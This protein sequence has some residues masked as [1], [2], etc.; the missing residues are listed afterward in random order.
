MR[1][2]FRAR[3]KDGVQSAPE[4]ETAVIRRRGDQGAVAV[5]CRADSDRGAD[6]RFPDLA[7]APDRDGL[8]AA[9]VDGLQYAP[10]PA[11]EAD[12]LAG[13]RAVRRDHVLFD[14]R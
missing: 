4:V 2:Q 1:A 8:V 11:L 10:L 9:P 13:V 5:H 6:E 3:L 14:P 12:P 7:R